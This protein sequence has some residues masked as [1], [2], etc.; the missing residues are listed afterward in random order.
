MLPQMVLG[1]IGIDPLEDVWGNSRQFNDLRRRISI[2]LES[3]DEC[4]GCEY[5]QSC[6]G[7]CA[8]TALSLSKDPNRPSLEACLKKFKCDLA[9]EGLSIWQN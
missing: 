1:Y 5:L 9:A 4:T 2:P 3:F 8:G 6:T 7:N